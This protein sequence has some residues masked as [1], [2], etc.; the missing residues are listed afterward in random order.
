MGEQQY[1]V[2]SESVAAVLGEAVA[3]LQTFTVDDVH[4]GATDVDSRSER[5]EDRAGEVVD[6]H[7]RDTDPAVRAIG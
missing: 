7:R 2:P 6:F 5:T 1:G 4:L 3:I